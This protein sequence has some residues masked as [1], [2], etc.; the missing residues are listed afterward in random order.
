MA[1]ETRSMM[2]LVP[3]WIILIAT[4][5]LTFWSVRQL[6]VAII[7][8][9][10]ETPEASLAKTDMYG[11]GMGMGYGNYCL[12]PP[13]YP[14]LSSSMMPGTTMTKEDKTALEKYNQDMEKY[15]AEYMAACKAEQEKQEK[16]KERK[17]NSAWFSSVVV[18]SILTL[19]GIFS[20]ALT[21]V[22]IKKDEKE[23]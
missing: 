8:T 5:V 15:N 7:K 11:G 14:P 23:A 18:Y 16:S 12:I 4:L 13:M 9:T 20:T 1:N 2:R 6:A 22:V 21:L 10:T 3:L 19:F 17:L